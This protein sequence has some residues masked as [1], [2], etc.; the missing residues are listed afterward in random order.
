MRQISALQILKNP[1]SHIPFPCLGLQRGL[2]EGRPA[3]STAQPGMRDYRATLP[4]GLPPYPYNC[5]ALSGHL[6]RTTLLLSTTPLSW[7]LFP[8]PE[9]PQGASGASGLPPEE[10]PLSP[11]SPLFQF[12]KRVRSTQL[13][14]TEQTMML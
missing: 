8:A 13:P 2:E 7:A 1:P 14:E 3:L 12:S 11:A 9:R 10:D 6:T 4:L 5:A